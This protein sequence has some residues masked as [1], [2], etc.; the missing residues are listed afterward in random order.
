MKKYDHKKV[1]KKWQKVWEKEEPYKAEDTSDKEKFYCLIEFPYPSGAGLHVGHVRSYAALDVMVRKARMEGKNVLY[2]IGWDAFGLPTENYAIKHGIHPIEATK[3]NVKVFKRQIKGLGISFDWSREINTTEPEYYKWT[4]WIFL[5]LYKKGLAYKQEM[6]I[7]WCPSCKIGLAN[8]EV[9]N[10]AC[11]RC[12]TESER[13]NIKQWMLKITE[14]ADRLIED[15]ETVNYLDKIKIQQINWIGRSY[16]ANVNFK[17]K[18]SDKQ[19]EVYTTRPDTL[20]GATYMVLAPEHE[21]VE[22]LITEEYRGEVYEYQE[23]ARHK[24]DL[25]RTELSKDK[26]GV[27]TGAYAINPVNNEEIPIWIADYVLATYGTG[28][29]MAVPAH[30]E[31]DFEFAKKFELP[32]H[33]VIVKK[34]G[35]TNPKADRRDAVAAVVKNDDKVLVLYNKKFDVYR[36][37]SGGYEKGE[38]AEETIGREMLEETGYD[39]F[40]ITGY[41]GMINANFYLVDKKVQREKFHK[42]FLITLNSESKAETAFEDHEDYEGSWC[43]QQEAIE[44]LTP[45]GG[46]EEEFVRRA[47]DPSLKCFAGSEGAMV[48]SDFLNG[49]D[50]ENAMQAMNKWLEDKGIGKAAKSYKLRDWVFSRQHYWG[51]PIPIVF[52]D[53]CGEVPVPEEQL[54]ITLPMVEKY[55][56]TDTGESPL[57]A[58]EDWVNTTC[59]TCGGV[60]KRETDTMPNWAGSSWYFLRY[61]D[62]KNK[63]EFVAQDKLKYWM[64]VDLYNGGMEHTTLHLLYSRFW[65]KFLYDI[66]AVPVSE[67]YKR[68]VSHGMILATDGEKMSKSRGNVINPDDVVEEYGADVLRTYEMFIGPYDQSVSWDTNGIKGVKRFLDKVWALQEKY[69]ESYTFNVDEQPGKARDK[70]LH[71]V[72]KEVTNDVESMKFNTAVSSIMIL[73]NSL[74]S[75]EKISKFEIEVLLSLLNPFAPHLVSEITETLKLKIEKWPV[76]DPEKAII[77]TKEIVVQVNGKNRDK[78]ALTAD[79]DKFDEDTIKELALKSENVKKY[80]AGKEPKRVIYIKDKLVNIVV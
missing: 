50:V 4:Q 19:V 46:G 66:G 3:E 6:P 68:R 54:P 27:F 39:D 57:A 51:E 40:E 53:K 2:P 76:F 37:P 44:K 11:E 22:T 7:N 55:E 29:I 49:L 45:Y 48:N 43:T 35:E 67:P 28:A 21:L 72:I 58:I 62:P 78:I 73:T 9:V 17:V 26:T 30:D 10:G 20:F 31:R 74:W 34:F 1:E 23:Q 77:V 79:E 12:G 41:L 61:L 32:I 69:D 63:K 14:Y 56:P 25:E 71:Q 52:C 36:L 33:E 38:T 8:E 80:L 60:A 65:N 18:D 59:P 64:P 15:L 75:D 24:S 70:L 47:F 42:G 16:G 5:Q 13:R